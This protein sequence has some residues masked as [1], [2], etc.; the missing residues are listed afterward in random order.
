M[1]Q[2][3]VDACNALV[4]IANSLE[5]LVNLIEEER[6]GYDS[7]EKSQEESY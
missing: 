7:R 6:D 1:T 3:E 4:R 2:L 5:K